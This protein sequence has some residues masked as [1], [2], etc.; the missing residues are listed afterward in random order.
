MEQDGSSRRDPNWSE[1]VR[2]ANKP[3]N[4]TRIGHKVHTSTLLHFITQGS[5]GHIDACGH[6]PRHTLSFTVTRKYIPV[7]AFPC[8]PQ[9]C[10]ITQNTDS[11]APAVKHRHIATHMHCHT[12]D[13]WTPPVF[14]SLGWE[15]IPRAMVS[16]LLPPARSTSLGPDR[17]SL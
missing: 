1:H 7:T 13:T 4:Q 8:H 5:H 11:Q 10:P 6:S 14:H 17:G 9:A 12:Q 16:I 2:A 15:E 3:Y